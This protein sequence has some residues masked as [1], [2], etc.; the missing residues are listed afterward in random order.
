[1]VKKCYDIVF[2]DNYNSNAKGFEET[3]EFCKDYI[4]MYNGTNHSYF[5]DYKGGYVQIVNTITGEV[6]YEE[7]V[8]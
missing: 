8:E 3:F 1:M 4:E 2:H 6:D 5:A 7:D